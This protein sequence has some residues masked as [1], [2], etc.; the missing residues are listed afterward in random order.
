MKIL[1]NEEVEHPRSEVAATEFDD[2][3]QKEYEG[4]LKELQSQNDFM[5]MH[6]VSSS[7]VANKEAIRTRW[8]LKEQGEGVKARLVMKHF[9]TWEDENNDFYVRTPIP[10]SF[11]LV[12]T[13]RTGQVTNNCV[14]RCFHCV[15]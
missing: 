15:S 6:G 4:K 3:Q 5:S 2:W 1:L 11:N 7:E 10:V 14:S 12:L 13:S 8:V 9:N